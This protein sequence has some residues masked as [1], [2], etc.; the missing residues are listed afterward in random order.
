MLSSQYLFEEVTIYVYIFRKLIISI[1]FA[2]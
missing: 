1:Q 2:K